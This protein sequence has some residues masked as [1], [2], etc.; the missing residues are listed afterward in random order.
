MTSLPT[1]QRLPTLL[2][3]AIAWAEGESEQVLKHGQA[4]VQRDI[5]LAVRAGVAHPERVRIAVVPQMPWPG[6]E[7]LRAAGE[8]TG[9]FSPTIIGLTMGH[10]ILLIEGRFNRRMI[11]HELRHVHQYE[12]AGSIANF[13]PLYLLEV[14]THTYGN[15]PFEIDARNH[16]Y[17]ADETA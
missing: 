16:E 8:E 6:D 1:V 7:E 15:A 3:K 2:P 17:L 5:Q 13:L 10:G 9:L 4:L 12:A 11:A 14:A